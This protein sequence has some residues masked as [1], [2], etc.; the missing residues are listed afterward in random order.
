MALYKTAALAI[1]VELVDTQDLKSCSERRVWVQIP[2]IALTV[3]SVMQAIYTVKV[4]VE[5]VLIR[6][7]TVRIAQNG[8]S[9]SSLIETYAQQVRASAL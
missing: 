4:F 6:T 1:L 8:S 2:Q 3:C 7:S 5:V 9:A